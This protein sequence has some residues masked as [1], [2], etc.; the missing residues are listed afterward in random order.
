MLVFDASFPTEKVGC[1]DTELVKEFFIA[2]V[3]HSEVT[4]HIRMLSGENSH[5]IAE[6]MFKSVARSLAKAA[7]IDPA[8]AG[9]IPSTKGVI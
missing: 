5:H 3:R 7:A 1:F 4:L 9:E 6:G 8:A 2:F